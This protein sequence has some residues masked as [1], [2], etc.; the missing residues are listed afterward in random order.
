MS[1]RIGLFGGTF[2]PVHK[3]HVSIAHSFLQSEII[4]QLWVLL[5][6]FPPHKKGEEHVS[7]SIRHEML[8]VA[9]SEVENLSI[10]TIENE[11][12]KPSFSFNTVKHL[13]ELHPEVTFFFCM[14][15]DS[16]SKFHTWKHHGELIK[17]VPL[18]VAQRPGANHFEVEKYILERTTFVEHTP[19]NVSSSK[20]KELINSQ[21]QLLELLPKKVLDIILEE[22]LYKKNTK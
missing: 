22:S 9:F 17:E 2:D 3:G 13:K 19:I 8:E 21:D 6:P 14:G 4:D 5:T 1:R 12:P 7:Y 18:L 10:M 15:E 16:L 20:I 11:L